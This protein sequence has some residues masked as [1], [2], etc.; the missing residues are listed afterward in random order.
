MDDDPV[1][2]DALSDQ[3]VR[4]TA[5]PRRGVCPPKG[6]RYEGVQGDEGAARPRP[7]ARCGVT[8]EGFMKSPD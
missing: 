8:A 6:G 1:R 4:V 7:A 3:V 2:Q 5:A